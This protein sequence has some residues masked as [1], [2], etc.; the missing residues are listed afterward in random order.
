MTDEPSWEETGDPE[1]AA[2]SL[3]SEDD[4]NRCPTCGVEIDSPAELER[5][6]AG[7]D[8]K[9]LDCAH[10]DLDTIIERQRGPDSRPIDGRTRW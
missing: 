6:L 8:A 1:S 5:H 7:V 10:Q 9:R 2:G 3:A 4:D